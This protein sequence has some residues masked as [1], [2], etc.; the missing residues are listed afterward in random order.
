MG[1]VN[2]STSDYITMAVKPYGEEMDDFD[3]ECSYS[4]DFE[5]AEDILSEYG[6]YYFHIVLKPGYYEGF[7]VDIENNFP[8]AFDN[9]AEKAAAQKEITAIKSALFS[10]ADYGLVSCRP[11]WCSAYDDYT[12]TKKAIRSAIREM[13]EEVRSTP[14][15]YIYNRQEVT[16]A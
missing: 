1:A 10:L 7:S 5:I 9:W 3:R 11:G 6:F 16:T 13:R 14:T 8:V 15:W 4:A 2:Y 12:G